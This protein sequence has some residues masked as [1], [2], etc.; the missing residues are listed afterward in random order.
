MDPT[1][2]MNLN[3]P[4]NQQVNIKDLY[5]LIATGRLSALALAALYNNTWLSS[6]YGVIGDGITNDGPAL[7][8]LLTNAAAAGASVTLAQGAIVRTTVKIVV[9]SNTRLNG[10]GGTIK[11]AITS[12]ST[13]TIECADVSNILIENLTINGDKSA[14]AGVTE[15]KAGIAMTTATRV[16][17]RNITSYNNKG[18]GFYFRGDNNGSYCADI[19]LDN[20]RSSLAGVGNHRNG[21][22]V[23][24]GERIRYL[25][26]AYCYSDGTS[27][28]AGVDI[29]PNLVTDVIRDIEFDSVEFSNNGGHGLIFDTKSGSNQGTVRV[30]AGRIANNGFSGISL[31]NSIDFQIDGGLIENNSEDGITHS[32]TCR[33]TR[34]I[35]GRIRKNGLR[36]ISAFMNTGGYSLTGLVVIGCSITDNSQTTPNSSDGIRTDGL[37]TD[38]CVAFCIITNIDGVTQRYGISSGASATVTKETY[39]HNELVGNAT[40]TFNLQG[41]ASSRIYIDP[42]FFSLTNLYSGNNKVVGARKTGWATATGTATRT[43][44][45]TTT[46]TLPQLAERVKA[47]IDDLNSTAG[48]GLIGP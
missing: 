30:R 31:I 16:I 47:L 3:L 19:L 26:G 38:T 2:D 33:G 17:L 6:A 12:L 36:G 45:D 9:P 41:Q 22:S 7:N 35:G 43:T 18:D 40:A 34:V 4:N 46:V 23:I 5:D 25:G 39:I 1:Q 44:F 8:T 10:N 27:P 11:C 21:S 14:F 20:C 15:A 28:E 32:G 29:E 48:H 24:S 42:S 13:P 37:V